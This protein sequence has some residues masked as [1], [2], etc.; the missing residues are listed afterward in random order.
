LYRGERSQTTLL[1]VEGNQ[2]LDVEIA[3]AVAICQAK[4]FAI[5][6]M[7]NALQAAASHRGFAGIDQRDAPRLNAVVQEAQ[8]ALAH[9][10]GHVA[11]VQDVI[12][13]VFLDVVAFVAAAD[14]EIVDP[15]V[16]VQLHDVPKN[17]LAADL[18]HRL[19]FDL[20]FFAQS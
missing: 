6:M 4:S 20:R 14:D 1:P 5:Q 15:V 18:D 8:L 17:R 3:H 2:I 10:E 13:E 7:T 16:G 19:R 11:H 12:G 9:V